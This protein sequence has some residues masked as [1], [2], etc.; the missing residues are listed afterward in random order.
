MAIG[1]DAALAHGRPSAPLPAASAAPGSLAGCASKCE[2][3]P[4]SNADD[5]AHTRSN[6]KQHASARRNE[7]DRRRSRAKPRATPY[8]AERSA[9]TA[10]ERFSQ[11]TCAAHFC[12]NSFSVPRASHSLMPAVSIFARAAVNK[13]PKPTPASG[14]AVGSHATQ[15]A[16]AA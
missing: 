12:I 15:A 6:P 13:R 5:M 1:R 14:A 8:T 16:D 4:V 11:M 10:A 2:E 3:C 7:D 9:L